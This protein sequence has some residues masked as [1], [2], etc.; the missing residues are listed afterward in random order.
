[1]KQEKRKRHIAKAITWRVTASTTTALIA[2]VVTGS[3]KLGLLV[4]GFES[5]AKIA[6]Y[7]FHERAWLRVSFGDGQT[8][9][10]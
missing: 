3:I 9:E 10:K 1:M 8:P 7:Y 4:G 5:I 6:L 2:W